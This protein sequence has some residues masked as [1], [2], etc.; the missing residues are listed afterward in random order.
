[1]GKFSILASYVGKY[2]LFDIRN[3]TMA[4][5]DEAAPEAKTIFNNRRENLYANLQKSDKFSNIWWAFSKICLKIQEESNIL[6][7][8]GV[9][10]WTPLC[11]V[12]CFSIAF[13]F[14]PS[15]FPK[16]AGIG[17]RSPVRLNDWLSKGVRE[18]I[19][20]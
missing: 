17:L 4:V 13:L 15:F 19:P 9:L 14:Q 8:E 2:E 1:M 5:L 11:Y 20:T 18:R 3:S 16:N 10:W 6:L 12:L 7:Y